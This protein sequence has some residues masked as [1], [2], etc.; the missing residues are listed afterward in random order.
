MANFKSPHHVISEFLELYRSFPCLW[1][2]K[3]NEYSDT[4]KKGLAYA[5]LI[6]KC[7]VS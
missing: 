6:K 4:N 2:M 5:D 1:K 3:S 7:W